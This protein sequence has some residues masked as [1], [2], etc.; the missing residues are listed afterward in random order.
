MDFDFAMFRQFADN[1]NDDR[2]VA[3]RFYDKAVKTTAMNDNGLPIF[4]N[5]TYVE[6]RLKDNNTEVFNQPA[7]PEKIERFPREYALYKMAKAQIKEGTPLEQFAFLTAAEIATCKNRGIFTVEALANLSDDKVKSLGLQ[8]EHKF[9][10][11]F[12]R[13][14]KSNNKVADFARK[15]KEYADK[16]AE[17]KEKFELLNKENISLKQEI[18]KLNKTKTLR[19]SKTPK[20]E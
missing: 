5:V 3:A 14:A 8:N 6:I 12:M 15:E 1:T 2:N 18:I 20:G 13:N 4:K 16:I 9:A 11:I 7:S 10:E 19:K 17:Y